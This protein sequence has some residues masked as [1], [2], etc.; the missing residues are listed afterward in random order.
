[1]LLRSILKDH[2]EIKASCLEIRTKRSNHDYGV[3]PLERDQYFMTHILPLSSDL[4]RTRAGFHKSC[5][6]RPL[7]KAEKNSLG[8]HVSRDRKDLKDFYELH[9][10][11]RKKHGTPPQPYRYYLKMWDQ[12]HPRGMMELFLATHSGAAI[13]GIILLRFKDTVI[14]QA[15][16]SN[17]RV[18]SLHPNHF[19]LWQA[20]K[21]AHADGYSYFDL[22]RSSF[23]DRGLVQFKDRWGAE[24][25]E[26]I[27]YFYPKVSGVTSIRQNDRKYRVSTK[28][29]RSLPIP[30]LRTIGSIGYRYLG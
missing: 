14:Y 24:R 29:F 27:Y 25:H 13:A 18:L 11:T 7:R 15:G 17:E 26:L 6:Q 4:L 22:G 3:L 28:L 20:I 12:L 8:L 21:R 30:V 23:D 5:I 2:K 9:L 1:M 19:L 16:A 10:R